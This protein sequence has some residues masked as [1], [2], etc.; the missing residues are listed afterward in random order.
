MG[1]IPLV[2]FKFYFIL[3]ISTTQESSL[4]KKT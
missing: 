4:H 2:I 1:Q 3:D